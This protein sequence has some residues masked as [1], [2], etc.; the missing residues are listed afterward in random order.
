MIYLDNAASEPLF[1]SVL[2]VMNRSFKDDFANPS[3]AHGLG[4]KLSQKIETCRQKFLDLLSLSPEKWRFVFTGSATESNNMIILGADL[5]KGR[6]VC[7]SPA[8]HPS[9]IRPLSALGDQGIIPYTLPFLCGRNFSDQEL[10]DVFPWTVGF[11][12]LSQVNGQSGGIAP[13]AQLTKAAKKKNPATLIHIDG[14]QAFGKIP[15]NLDSTEI[16]SYSI[17][18]HKIGG[19]KG[20]SGLYLKRNIR[21]KPL[22][23]GGGQEEGFRPSTLAAPLIVGFGEAARQ[24]IAQVNKNREK[25][26]KLKQT[27]LERL[28]QVSSE[29]QFPFASDTESSPYIITCITPTFPS[30]VLM[31]CLEEKG[32]ILSSTSACSSKI[33]GANPAL[34]AMGIAEHLHKHV[35]RISF[36]SQTRTEEI[37]EF[38]KIFSTIWKE[39]CLLK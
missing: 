17:S 23:W 2:E 7:Y 10:G 11:L 29:I 25:A 13:I 26:E 32:V 6:S 4:L 38:V 5:Q 12:A 34:A 37:Q 15:V 24:C 39:L 18:S 31:R 27:C 36:S 19:P 3:S 33:K 8:D 20:I 28:G 14:S 22:M 16:D 1:P 21:L 35:L 9:M 30:D